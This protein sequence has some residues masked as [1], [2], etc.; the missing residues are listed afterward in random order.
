ME[1]FDAV[2]PYGD[3]PLNPERLSAVRRY[4]TGL[5]VDIGCGGGAYVFE[6]GTR[7]PA[8][9]VDRTRFET[10]NSAPG[11]FLQ[12]DASRL[13]LAPDSVD[14]LLC[15]ETLEHLQDPVEALR[16]YHLVCRGR[17]ILSVPNCTLTP[18][19]R[20]SNVIFHHWIDRTHRSFFDRD[21]IGSTL[22]TAGF[23][24]VEIRNINRIDLFPLFG[25]TLRI[26]VWLMR[27]ARKALRP[28]TRR[29]PM[30]LLVVADVGG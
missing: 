6:L 27:L 28:L 1:S 21:S 8:F 7:L 29:Y 4:A 23:R 19:M 25:E 10:W 17:L 16:E 3:R 9:G 24:V 14:T 30:T 15:F 13:P 12:C 11:R 22:E 26:P 20:Q 18:G 2:A 5:T